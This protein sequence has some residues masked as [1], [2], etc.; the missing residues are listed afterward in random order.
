[1]P[2][3]SLGARKKAHTKAITRQV[4][5]GLSWAV[6]SGRP[7]AALRA[8]SEFLITGTTTTATIIATTTAINATDGTTDEAASVGGLFHF[9]PSAQCRLLAHSG[10]SP[11]R[12]SLSAFGQERTTVNF[13]R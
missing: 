1:M 10:H 12:N 4:R 13:C 5:S 8:R 3:E 11:R 9:K 2:R 6:R 7:S